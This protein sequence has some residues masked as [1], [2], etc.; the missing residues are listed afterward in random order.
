MAQPATS[1]VPGPVDPAATP[2]ALP[3]GSTRR[4]VLD[5]LKRRPG[6]TAPGLAEEL[7]ITGAAVRQHLDALADAGLVDNRVLASTGPGRPPLGWHLTPRA[8]SL[9]PDAHGEL[10]VAL[11]DAISAELGPGALDR[12]VAARVAA[13]EASY[14]AEVPARSGLRKRVEALA[15]RRTAEGYAAEVQAEGRDLHLIERHC[16]IGAAA[17]A[18]AG[19]CAGE[20]DLFQRILGPGVVVER[21]EHVLAGDACCAYRIRG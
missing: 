14:R 19:L 17:R 6:S 13:Q 12:V 10:A 8:G 1:P 18:C 11:L 9:F 4:A 16:P 20:L 15:R 7:G 3:V 21:T 5:L 2:V